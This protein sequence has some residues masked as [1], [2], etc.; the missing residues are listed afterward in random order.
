MDIEEFRKYGHGL[1][2]WVADYF[3][4]IESYPVRSQVEPGYLFNKIP[5][6]PPKEGIFRP[7]FKRF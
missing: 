1:I 3:N 5:T 7:N 6:Q 4:N 2:D